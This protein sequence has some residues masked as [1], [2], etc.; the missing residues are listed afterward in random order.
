MGYKLI[1][2]SDRYY[3]SLDGSF[4]EDA[5]LENVL[6]SNCHLET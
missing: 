6:F 2:G 3:I 1:Y 5:E 4:L